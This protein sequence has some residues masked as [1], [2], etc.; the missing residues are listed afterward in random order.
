MYLGA[1]E[2]A[3]D[4]GHIPNVGAFLFKYYGHDLYRTS[5]YAV[6]SLRTGGSVLH[7]HSL[8]PR[9]RSFSAHAGKL[10]KEVDKLGE[11]VTSFLDMTDSDGNHPSIASGTN[12]VQGT[13]QQ[14]NGRT[15]ALD[16]DVR[17][18]EA[19]VH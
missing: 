5:K 12:K 10:I 14:A 1:G 3:A 11:T 18:L 4:Y 9:S 15:R 6:A 16:D 13:L 2:G 8:Q 17:R 7:L 19:T